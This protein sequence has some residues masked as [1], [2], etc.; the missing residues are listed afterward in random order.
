MVSG[1]TEALSA[2]ADDP[3]VREARR[4]GGSPQA[5]GWLTSPTFAQYQFAYL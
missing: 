4:G 3:V 5:D 2:R 1:D